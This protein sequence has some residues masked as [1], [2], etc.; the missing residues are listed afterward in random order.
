MTPLT[1]TLALPAS[2]LLASGLLAVSLPAAS[3]E[4]ATTTTLCNSQT[5]P[6]DG[7]A[8][9]VDNDEWGSSVPEC[10]TTDGSPEFRVANSSIVNARKAP[11]GGYPDIYK[12]CNYGACTQRS[13]LPIRVSKIHAG[14]V[15]TSWSTSQPGGRN[16]YNAAYD[17]WFNQAPTTSGAANGAELMI[18]LNHRG[19]KRPY[20]E[21]VASNVNIGGRDYNV[22]FG[23]RAGKH[24]WNTVS[25]TM[26]SRAHSVRKLDL[27]ALV[28]DAVRRGYIRTSWY[29]INVEA[30]FEVWQGGVGLATRS[31][32]VKVTR[33][34][35][36]H[37]AMS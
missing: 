6:V 28:A 29:L 31:F 2:L 22:W 33:H 11:P 24:N 37:A 16:I 30:G 19:R 27:R 10:I 8:Y 20:G 17:V 1:R 18:W 26:T 15:T 35:P 34:R 32:S 25:Y 9:T 4:A 21:Q 3:S 14:T 23:G 12:G 7:G 36:T 5:A 13:G